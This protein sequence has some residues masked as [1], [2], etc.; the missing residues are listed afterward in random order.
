VFQDGYTDN[1]AEDA[2]DNDDVDC[3]GDRDM[4]IEI[5]QN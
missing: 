5:D 3:K 2:G 4:K 1:G